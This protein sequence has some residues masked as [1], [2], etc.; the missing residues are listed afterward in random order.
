MSVCGREAEAERRGA[1][2]QWGRRGSKKSNSEFCVSHQLACFHKYVN[3]T[4]NLDPSASQSGSWAESDEQR[5][6]D[7][8]VKLQQQQVKHKNRIREAG[9]KLDILSLQVYVLLLFFS[10]QLIHH[11]IKS[12][13]LKT[14]IQYL[15]T[16][17][18]RE[19]WNIHLV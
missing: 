3:V 11:H 15:Y 13:H 7:I 12:V 1:N 5:R 16:T 4:S 10:K 19:L 8:S 2:I 14:V 18:M 17:K 6:L 9:I